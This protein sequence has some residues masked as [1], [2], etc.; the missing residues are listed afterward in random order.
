MRLAGK[1]AVITAAASGM[2]RAGV[3]LF[4]RE[5]ARVVAV[6]VDAG[7]LH[8][9]VEDVRG[10][11]GDVQAIVA[12]LTQV[13]A[14]KTFV[15]EAA[16]LLG[17]IDILWNHA[18]MP[19]PAAI[20]NLDLPAYETS[21]ALNV[22]SGI[23]A[24]GQVIGHMRKR[25]GGSIVFTASVSGIVGSMLSPIYSSQK[26]AVVGLTMSLAQRFAPDMVRVNAICPGP[27]DTAMLPGFLARDGGGANELAANTQKVLSAIPMGRVGRPEEIAHAALWLASDDSSYVTGIALP[28]DGGMVCR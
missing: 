25:G 10:K 24:S 21:L 1:L 15:D 12:D 7:K 6:D 19:G 17:G 16:A 18:G 9:L 11:G 13:E 2:G 26:F 3:E 23:I 28:V 22:T 8:A 14:C 5:G 27:I 4:I 20:E